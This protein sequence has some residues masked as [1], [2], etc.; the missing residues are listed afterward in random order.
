MRKYYCALLIFLV[1]NSVLAFVTQ[2]TP[3]VTVEGTA[4]EE[5]ATPF[6]SSTTVISEK[7]LREKHVSHAAD[8]FREIPGVTLSPSGGLGQPS[9]I[10]I[11]GLRS[12]DTLVIIDG[13]VANDAMSPGRTFDAATLESG[14]I[15]KIEVLRGP[16][17]VRFG[18]NATGGVI[19]I[20]TKTGTGPTKIS[21][22]A[23]GGS[24]QSR[25]GLFNV[26]GETSTLDYSLGADTFSTVGYPASNTQGGNLRNGYDRLAF[27]SK[28]GLKPKRTQRLEWTT[29]LQIGHSELPLAPSASVP[30][31]SANNRQF[32]TGLQ[33]YEEFFHHRLRS[34][35]QLSFSEVARDDE[36]LPGTPPTQFSKNDFLSETQRVYTEQVWLMSPEQKL[37]FHGLW[38]RE[39]GG[40]NSLTSTLNNSVA[41]KEQT[42][43]GAGLQYEWDNSVWQIQAGGRVDQRVTGESLSTY[44]L[45]AGRSLL[46]DRSLRLQATMASAY[47]LPSLF[48]LYS[49]YGNSRL[50][51]EKVVAIEVSVQKKWSENTT[52]ALTAF[53][54]ASSNLINFD[55]VTSKYSNIGNARSRGIELQWTEIFSPHFEFLTGI[56]L[57]ETRDEATGRPLVRRPD[58]AGQVS[59]KFRQEGY[60]I[61]LDY[62]YISSR[63]DVDPVSFQNIRAKPYG[64]VALRGR[65][66]ITPLWRVL[67]RVENV[68]DQKYD[69]IAGYPAAPFSIFVG[70]EFSS[71]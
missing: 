62:R 37:T 45:S 41:R 46:A 4:D 17:A 64:V 60:D 39:T 34:S 3:T 21:A 14:N 6:A 26:S 18:P 12:E 9:G 38:Q 55:L 52:T 49:Q 5:E 58:L 32:S 25:R 66:A 57:L 13:I 20:T 16:Q 8:L 63:E 50:Q 61:T 54:I 27:T 53:D 69:E 42:L 15:E 22:L 59:G 24:F 30:N 28:L 23:E 65:Y 70:L 68:L 19:L 47:R 71:Q 35:L 56:T 44:R 2:T 10:L 51:T 67:G 33:A 40:L 7:T 29:R 11:R 36:T 31:S 48:Q 1:S 43:F